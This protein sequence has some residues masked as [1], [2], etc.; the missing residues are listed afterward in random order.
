MITGAVL[1]PMA[2]LPLDSS[3]PERAETFGQS[4]ARAAT[5]SQKLKCLTRLLQPD[6]QKYV[7]REP[8]SSICLGSSVQY[9]LYLE[10]EVP[11]QVPEIQPH[12]PQLLPL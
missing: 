4:Q 8:V 7:K 2:L 10:A 5:H 9:A 3:P 1:V 11:V 6:S 12:C